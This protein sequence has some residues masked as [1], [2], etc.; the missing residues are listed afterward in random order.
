MVKVSCYG[1]YRILMMNSF[2]VISAIFNFFFFFFHYNARFARLAWIQNMGDNSAKTKLVK[3][4]LVRPPQK[5][6]HVLCLSLL[7]QH[8]LNEKSVIIDYKE[9]MYKL[10]TQQHSNASKQ[11]KKYFEQ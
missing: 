5:L 6:K 3:S 7:V 8:T 1:F 2:L 11:W 4:R 9:L 10:I